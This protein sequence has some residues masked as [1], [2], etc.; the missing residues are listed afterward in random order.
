MGFTLSPRW[1]DAADPGRL[2]FLSSLPYVATMFAAWRNWRERHR[3]PASLALHA[4]AI[5]MLVL[6]GVLVVVQLIEGAWGLWWRPAG[7]VAASYVLQWIG[8]A[9]EGNDMGEL[10]VIKK[11]MG[12]PY[13]AVAPLRRERSRRAEES[14]GRTR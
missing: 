4:V 2:D 14:A 3:H 6:A 9:I 7:L 11:L 8:H 12:K 1:I 10:I 13:V 5:P